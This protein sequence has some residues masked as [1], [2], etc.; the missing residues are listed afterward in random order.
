MPLRKECSEGL[1]AGDLLMLLAV[2]IILEAFRADDIVA[3]IGGNKFAALLPETDTTIAE[4]VVERIMNSTEILNGQVRIA[5]G[6][7]SAENKDQVADALKLSEE[8]MYRDNS[9]RKN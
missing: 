5:F 1:V 6:I 9:A 8:R 2:K 7:A 3:R 4:E